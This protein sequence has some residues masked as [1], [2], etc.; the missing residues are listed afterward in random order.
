[1]F[2]LGKT[3]EALV[4]EPTHEARAPGQPH[5]FIPF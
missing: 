1:M 2:I 5:N 3:E 4:D